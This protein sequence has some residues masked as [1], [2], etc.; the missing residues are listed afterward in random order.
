[1]STCT[2]FDYWFREIRA[3]RLEQLIGTVRAANSHSPWTL[4]IARYAHLLRRGTPQWPSYKILLQ[5]ATQM[6][7]QHPVRI[8]AEHWLDQDNCNWRWLRNVTSDTRH[9]EPEETTAIVMEHDYPDYPRFSGTVGVYGA[10]VLRDGTI[11]SWGGTRTVR[12]WTPEGDPV[13]TLRGHNYSVHGLIEEESGKLLAWSRV[14]HVI[15]WNR[16]GELLRDYEVSDTPQES[17]CLNGVLPAPQGRFVTY[18]SCS[19]GRRLSLWGEDDTP[20]ASSLAPHDPDYGG[21]YCF[22][23]DFVSWAHQT[24]TDWG[25]SPKLCSVLDRSAGDERN[26][27][28]AWKGTAVRMFDCDGAFT[29]ELNGHSVE[30]LGAVFTPGGRIVTWGA[31]A[32]VVVWSGDGTR[33][34]RLTGH[35]EMVVHVLVDAHDTIWSWDFNGRLIRWDASGVVLGESREFGYS[36]EGAQV[37]SDQS[38]IAWSDRGEFFR[39]TSRGT[40]VREFCGHT[41]RIM[42]VLE[43]DNETILSWSVDGTVRLWT[44]VFE[45]CTVDTTR[46]R[47]DRYAPQCF[48]FPGEGA[49]ALCTYSS[50]D[51]YVRVWSATGELQARIDTTADGIRSA[52]PLETG[53][54]SAVVW[55]SVDGRVGI[56]GTDGCG[57]TM[58][59]IDD[60]AISAATVGETGEILVGTAHGTVAVY[61]ADGSLKRRMHGH[62]AYVTACHW[63]A[64]EFYITA[65]QDKTIRIWTGSECDIITMPI[66]GYKFLVREDGSVFAWT[67]RGIVVYQ[68]DHRTITHTQTNE[69]FF[70]AEWL[71]DGTI[72]SATFGGQIFLWN[73][74]GTLKKRYTAYPNGENP[75]MILEKCRESTFITAELTSESVD[76]WGS[77]GSHIE[78]LPFDQFELIA[79]GCSDQYEQSHVVFSGPDGTTFES[80]WC[81][82]DRFCRMIIDKT[83]VVRFHTEGEAAAWDV[84]SDGTAI[85]TDSINGLTVVRL[86]E[87][88]HPVTLV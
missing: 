58:I 51:R 12:L 8:A 64:S 75:E 55:R 26:G 76:R 37:L 69:Y 82:G 66:S 39:Y 32:T 31:D 47:S 20:I 87:G 71:E 34:L 56:S 45:E 60:D 4:F 33:L 59:K 70:R 80:F 19:A 46:M 78:S 41:D 72:A 16:D 49:S 38:I 74:D 53:S 54:S 42:G 29:A 44:A 77:D 68:P 23:P 84:L 6:P 50:A 62:V 57:S 85:L 9:G 10:T 5:L 1:M 52:W 25:V 22:N 79:L 17:A 86:F 81:S 3:G 11:A 13:Q 28:L 88:K 61:A 14:N 48:T 24:L 15:R 35:T 63:I 65:A 27:T 83:E 2:E 43:C 7:Q 30:V 67:N 21:S 40:V 73:A 18:T 36:I